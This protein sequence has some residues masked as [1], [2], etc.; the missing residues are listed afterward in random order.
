MCEH[1]CAISSPEFEFDVARFLQSSDQR[2]KDLFPEAG[3][4]LPSKP[5]VNGF[6]VSEWSG[7]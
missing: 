3:L 4:H 6:E 5:I 1:D 2:F 7:R